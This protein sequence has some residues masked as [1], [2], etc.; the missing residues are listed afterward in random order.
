MRISKKV[1][2]LLAI[3]DDVSEIL[4]HLRDNPKPSDYAS[5]VLKL[6]NSSTEHYDEWRDDYF[7]NW[8][9]VE[10]WEYKKY[11]YDIIKINHPTEI[12]QEKKDS[13]CYVSDLY[14]IKIGWVIDSGGYIEGPYIENDDIEEQAFMAF[15][16]MIWDFV[17]ANAVVI[18]KKGKAVRGDSMTIFMP[19]NNKNIYPSDAAE[20]ILERSQSFIK[21]GYNRSIMLY[22]RAGTGKTSCM[23]YIAREIG[24][25]SLR[26][27]VKDMDNLDSDDILIAIAMLRP[28]T[29]IIDDFDRVQRPDRFLSDL[30]KFNDTIKLIMVSV[31]NVSAFDDAVIRPGRF[32]DIIKLEK[33]DKTIIDKLIG[34]VPESVYKRLSRLPIAYIGEFHKRREVLGEEEAIKEIEE[35]ESRIRK[36]K[37]DIIELKK[38]NRDED[39]FDLSAEDEDFDLIDEDPEEE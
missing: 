23:K 17:G 1:K 15:G 25:F 21:K 2:Q 3:A 33:L 8:H 30:E 34:E 36:A 7:K 10:I 22:G 26:I 6:L 18:A 16:R 32:D 13:T 11:L 35:L 20:K 37:E 29:L 19:D 27:N 31:N 28:D 39:D 4:I 12:V 9:Q 14:G 24:K 38:K 5:I